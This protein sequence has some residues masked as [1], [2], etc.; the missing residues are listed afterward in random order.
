MSRQ[1]TII[2]AFLSLSGIS[3]FAAPNCTEAPKEQ[4]MKEEA[5]QQ[6]LK[7]EGYEIKKFKKPGN[8]YEI[9]GKDKSG[10]KVEIYFN[11]AS[12]DIVKRNEF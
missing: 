1:I 10:K 12:G 11:P 5:F 8:C 2:F 6:K 3:A 7:A 9:Y 4:W